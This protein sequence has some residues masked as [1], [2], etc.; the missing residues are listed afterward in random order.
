MSF[1]NAKRW[2]FI[3]YATCLAALLALPVPTIALASGQKIETDVT[4]WIEYEIDYG[5]GRLSL[6]VPPNHRFRDLS[7]Y[8]SRPFKSL[9]PDLN[10]VFTAQYDYGWRRWSNIAQFEVTYTL[11]RL[12]DPLLADVSLQD[13]RLAL[14]KAIERAQDEPRGARDWSIEQFEGESS[15]RWMRS[16][17]PNVEY[18]ESFAALCSPTLALIVTPLYWG[19]DLASSLRW[20]AERRSLIRPLL[21]TVICE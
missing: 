10:Q 4:L 18:A 3:P 9:E 21:S 19:D 6:R 1:A 13:F 11:V 15:L 17:D 20:K 12:V 16:F 5:E 7:H 2:K 8:L 14:T